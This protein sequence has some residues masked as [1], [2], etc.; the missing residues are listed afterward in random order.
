MTRHWF[1]AAIAIL[2]LSA[3][4]ALAQQPAKPAAAP[5]K[6]DIAALEKAVSDA[7][8]PVGCWAN[9]TGE[10]ITMCEDREKGLSAFKKLYEAD[11]AKAIAAI[12]KRIDEIPSPKGGYF[13]I[14]AAV[15]TKDKAFVP[16]LKKL[17]EKQKENSLGT[18]ATEAIAVIETGKCTQ[19][20]PPTKLREICM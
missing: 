12:Q 8:G 5:A 15:T 9:N 6:V 16:M 19:T 11:K 7:P 3:A 4:S 10:P 13:P 14:L 2:S 20:P 1:V 18:W 17:A